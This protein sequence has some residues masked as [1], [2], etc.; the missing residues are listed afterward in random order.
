MSCLYN[1]FTG[2]DYS[3][4]NSNSLYQHI[5]NCYNFAANYRVADRTVGYAQPGLQSGQ[6]F[7]SLTVSAISAACRRDGWSDSCLSQPTITI[8][9]AIWPNTDFHFW[10][11]VASS[12]VWGNKPGCSPAAT[13]GNPAVAANR[14]HYTT[15]GEYFYAPGS[16]VVK[17]Y[18]VSGNCPP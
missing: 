12:Q 9:Y 7:G 5:N 8:C 3:F 6:V 18:G 1:Y 11:Q 15:F 17:G 13:S 16:R 14:G 4:W 2:T 10:R